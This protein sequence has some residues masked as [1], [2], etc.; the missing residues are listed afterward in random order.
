MSII[1]ELVSTAKTLG[2]TPDSVNQTLW[3]WSPAICTLV[4]HMYL[5]F[6]KIP[7]VPPSLSWR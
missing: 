6:E 7:E 1:W 5:K 3:E 2:L 4:T